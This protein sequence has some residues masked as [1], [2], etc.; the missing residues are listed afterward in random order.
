MCGRHGTNI[1]PLN[2]A[3]HKT[4]AHRQGQLEEGKDVRQQHG[5]NTGPS[6]EGD[7][8]EL[9]KSPILERCVEEWRGR[10]LEWG[11]VGWSVGGW[12]LVRGVCALSALEVRG[13]ITPSCSPLN[14]ASD[15]RNLP[16]APWEDDSRF[17]LRPSVCLIPS[18]PISAIL[19]RVINAHLREWL[20]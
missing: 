13:E 2:D 10:G 1:S 7:C 16:K 9:V 15:E 12:V 5:L 14:I 8:D 3:L 6:W 19:K 11:E 4:E 20:I 17:P 18:W